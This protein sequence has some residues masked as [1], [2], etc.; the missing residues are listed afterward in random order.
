[1]MKQ[2]YEN[3]CYILRENQEGFSIHSFNLF[4]IK[5]FDMMCDEF[6]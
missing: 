2:E 1:M 4:D 3:I 5:F 6:W